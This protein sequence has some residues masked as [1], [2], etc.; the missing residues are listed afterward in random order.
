MNVELEKALHHA[1][2]AKDIESLKRIAR[3]EARRA[4]NMR[5]LLCAAINAAGG[6]VRIPAEA[7]FASSTEQFFSMH[8]AADGSVTIETKK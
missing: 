8:F 3:T 1:G 6:K 7:Y 5:I 4:K 2:D